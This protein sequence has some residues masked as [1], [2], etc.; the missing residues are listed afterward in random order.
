MLSFDFFLFA[1]TNSWANNRDA[2][3]LRRHRAYYDVIV[4]N[5]RVGT[6]TLPSQT[7][8]G[9]Q[10]ETVDNTDNLGVRMWKSAFGHQD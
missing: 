2:G 5:D 7:V 10:K 8:F 9:E 1:W 6:G 4:M 3:D